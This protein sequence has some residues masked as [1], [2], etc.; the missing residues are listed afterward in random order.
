[1]KIPVKKFKTYF[2]FILTAF[3]TN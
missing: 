2:Q 1:M 3:K